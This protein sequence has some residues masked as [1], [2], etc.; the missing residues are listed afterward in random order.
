[1]VGLG[2]QTGILGKQQDIQVGPTETPMLKSMYKAINQVSK[3]YLGHY[4]N[5][6]LATKEMMSPLTAAA[7]NL[8]TRIPT[9]KSSGQQP[10]LL[11]KVQSY[12]DPDQGV[13]Y[14][15][16]PSVGQWYYHYPETVAKQ[17]IIE[18]ST[19][20]EVVADAQGRPEWAIVGDQAVAA[21]SAVEA[22][23]VDPSL[24]EILDTE[25]SE[26]SQAKTAVAAAVEAAVEEDKKLLQLLTAVEEDVEEAAKE[27]PKDEE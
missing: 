20:V 25:A 3:Y 2:G 15:F 23:S 1:M 17:A 18:P 9:A 24:N 11:P 21:S 13:E 6:L 16:D 8:M 26:L 4:K 22:S 12:F 19:Q 7:R 10:V 5:M 27:D 14:W